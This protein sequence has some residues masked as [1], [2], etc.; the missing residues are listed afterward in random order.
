MCLAWAIFVVYGSLVPLEFQA[1][2]AGAA[3]QRLVNAPMF[4]IDVHGRAD[5]IAN[6]VLYLPLGFLVTAVGLGDRRPGTARTLWAVLLALLS[7]AALAVTVEYAQAYFPPRT[8]SLNDL[9]AECIG[10]VFGALLAVA[11]TR[12]LQV[13][14]DGFR[15]GGALLQRRLAPA[16]AVAY[17]A[18]A[19]F[20]Y[21]LLL[22]GDEWRERL[23]GGNTGLLLA[24]APLQSGTALVLARLSAEL[25]AAMPLGLWWAAR[26]TG[27][28]QNGRG[29]NLPWRGALLR[30]AL[31]GLVIEIAQLCIASGVSQGA[32]VLSR[33][34]GFT[35]GAV[36]WN[37]RAAW[38]VESWR[39][40]LRRVTLPALAIYLPT[41]TVLYGWWRQP[42]LAW[43]AALA[44]LHTELHYLPF[45]YHYF[46]T[47]MNAVSSLVSVA[48][49]YAPV[50][51]L[52]WSWHVGART[53]G[54]FAM[55][56]ALGLEGCRLLSSVGHPD[57]TNLL[58]AGVSAWATQRLLVS[59]AAPPPR[60]ANRT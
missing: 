58:I 2:P 11:G 45:Y 23:Q 9:V 59:L 46:S 28:G 50:G 18:L 1:L 54:A 12:R 19:L 5:W 51:L 16:Y 55:L 7:S 43:D 15:A 52:A 40:L 32:S 42:W 38:P 31:L 44:R 10:S 48:L 29:Q 26:R 60:I 20:P 57:P 56:L 41:L 33:S 14:T 8:V 6:G 35:V 17:G 30:G 47:E 4:N 13:L 39:A 21:D 24:A 27:A 36:A 53:A 49:S 25:L 34:I 22:N 37:G 3:W